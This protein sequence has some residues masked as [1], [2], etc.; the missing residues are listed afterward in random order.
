MTARAGSP[1]TD[2]LDLVLLVHEGVFE[3][4]PWTGFLR[5]LRHRLH[6]GYA[7]VIFR[8][9]GSPDDGLTEWADAD[10]DPTEIHRSYFSAF[11]GHDP[12]P[13]FR[14]EPGKVLRMPDLMGRDDYHTHP[15]FT[16]FLQPNRLEHMLL[17]RVVEPE[18]H[19]AWVTV[20]RPL[21]GQPFPASAA[22]VCER[23]APHFAVALR[24]YG[25]LE[26][27]RMTRAIRDRAMRMANL[28][29]VSIDARRIPVLGDKDLFTRHGKVLPLRLDSAGK[30]RMVHAEADRRL[31]KVLEDIDR[32][33]VSAPVP[34]PI[35]GP[36]PGQA[37]VVPLTAKVARAS[38]AIANIYFQLP[39]DT[40][41]FG[42]EFQ[43]VLKALYS[44]S[45]TEAALAARLVEG[46]SL[47]DAADSVGLTRES[48]RT[49]SKRIFAKTGTSGQTDLVRAL[50]R[51]MAALA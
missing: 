39:D 9:P 3:E 22:D 36:S 47:H 27:A 38:T 5:A 28:G 10:D 46:D 50:L 2:L 30:L 43:Q 6:A 12:F 45:S 14:M 4:Q 35:P 48:A 11:A 20:T 44:L 16:G 8:R 40:A 33:A 13:Y 24:C 17:F 26:A 34:F 51:S 42:A 29:C 31:G 23:L 49:Y 25:E 21:D 1:D 15:Y 32:G 19:Q 41:R 37:L 18:G 7:N